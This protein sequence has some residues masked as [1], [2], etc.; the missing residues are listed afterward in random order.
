MKV[1]PPVNI[2]LMEST[3]ACYVLYELH[4]GGPGRSK[5]NQAAY[6]KSGLET[7]LHVWDGI[8]WIGDKCSFLPVL[9][10]LEA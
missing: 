1:S 9:G 8:V 4:W 3:E 5:G 6:S 2:N 7:V 10:V